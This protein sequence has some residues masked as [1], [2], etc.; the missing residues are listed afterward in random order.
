MHLA[1]AARAGHVPCDGVAQRGEAA[2]ERAPEQMRCWKVCSKRTTGR[3]PGRDFAFDSNA[4]SA[5]ARDDRNKKMGVVLAPGVDYVRS[6]VDRLGVPGKND[7]AGVLV[8]V[9]SLH[10]E[11]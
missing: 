7:P 5:L 11:A 8:D 10:H 4:R 9:A 2:R 3:G 6:R 1:I